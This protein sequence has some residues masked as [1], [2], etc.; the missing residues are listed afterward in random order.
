MVNSHGLLPFS[1]RWAGEK[2]LVVGRLSPS[3]ATN[4]L[5][6]LEMRASQ[7]VGQKANLEADVVT[8][9]ERK[10]IK[11]FIPSSLFSQVDYPRVS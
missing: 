3:P 7:R 2:R 8:T 5:P 4:G 1:L 9:L 10:S 11:N 6:W